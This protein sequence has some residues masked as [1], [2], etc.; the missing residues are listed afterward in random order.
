M[1]GFEYSVKERLM[2]SFKLWTVNDICHAI[3][4]SS[5]H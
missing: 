4:P 5:Y 2:S 3:K 1:S